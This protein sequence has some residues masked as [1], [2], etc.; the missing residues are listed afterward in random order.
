M[1]RGVRSAQPEKSLSPRRQKLAQPNL[2]KLNPAQRSP[3]QARIPLVSIII[4]CWNA[5][6]YV[7]DAIESALA[8]TYRPVEVIIIDDGSTDGSLDVIKSYDSRI[9]WETGPRRGGGAARNRGIELARGELVQFLDAD[10]ILYPNKLDVMVPIARSAG[11][12]VLAVSDWESEPGNDGKP[13]ARRSLPS[14]EGDAVLF[15]LRHQL[16]T[17]S[18]LHWRSNLAQVGGFDAA[19]P[20]C[21]EFDLHLRLAAHGLRL[22]RVAKPLYAVR[23]RPH[24]VS[25]DYVRVLDQ[26]ESIFI[27]ISD[28]L[29]ARRELTRIRRIAIAEALARDARHYL[30][31]GFNDKGKHYFHLAK[32]VDQEGGL[33]VFGRWY[34]RTLARFAGPVRAEHFIQAV[35]R[36]LK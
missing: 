33:G 1:E 28:V 30:R 18:P 2:E 4:P 12:S 16:Q 36:T 26:H 24:S 11:T 32:Q 5:E 27:G 9:H 29:Q 8:Q 17:C 15:C 23:K 6:S 21:Q 13:V 22:R 35:V 19:L 25:S 20:C 10:D 34:T 7:G 31:R 3:E 14:T